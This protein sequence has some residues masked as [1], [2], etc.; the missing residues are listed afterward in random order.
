MT[1]VTA[2]IRTHNR[3]ELFKRCIDSI[4]GQS[5]DLDYVVCS[6]NLNGDCYALDVLKQFRILDYNNV[7]WIKPSNGASFHYNTYCNALKS[8]VQDGW[9]FFLDDDDYLIDNTAIERMIPHLTDPSKAMI[10]QFMRN[11]FPKPPDALMDRGRIRQ[12]QIGMP[13]IF[14]HASQKDVAMFTD[15]E[16]ADFTFIQEVVSKIGAKFVKEVVVMSE[17]R[18]YGNRI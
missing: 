9:F 12:G 11:K 6:D 16:D 3:P 14:L 2:L 4:V 15:K 8:Q 13:C 1:Q 7:F 5:T 17:K 10:C 18:R